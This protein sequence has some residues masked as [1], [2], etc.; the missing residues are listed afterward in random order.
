MTES[1]VYLPH[2]L[3]WA[4]FYGI[5]TVVQLA[6]LIDALAL[7]QTDA[8][9]YDYKAWQWTQSYARDSS[10]CS[11]PSPASSAAVS[12]GSYNSGYVAHL[13]RRMQ[14]IELQISFMR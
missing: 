9:R 1:G 11:S 5:G 12:A 10:R 8:T 3:E 14:D 2:L 7:Y 6:E 13:Q 4:P